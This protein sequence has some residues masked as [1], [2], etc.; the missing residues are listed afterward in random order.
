MNSTIANV[1]TPLRAAF[2]LMV[3]NSSSAIATGP[4]SLTRRLILRRDL[5]PRSP[6]RVAGGVARL[7]RG[8]VEHR[9]DFDE[10]AQSRWAAA[11]GP[12]RA[13][14]RRSSP[15]G[16]PARFRAC[17]RPCRDGR[18]RLVE[19]QLV[20]VDADQHVLE[21]GDQPAQAL[22]VAEIADQ[23]RRP[24]S[25]PARLCSS[26]SLGWNSRPC[27]AK[28]SAALELVTRLKV[29]LVLGERLRS[30]PS[31]PRRSVPASAPRRRRR[32]SRSGGTRSRTR[33]RAWRQSRSFDSSASMSELMTKWVAV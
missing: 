27:W 29:A 33:P 6:Q 24:A 28:N 23:R 20:L 25:E 31:S 30:A 26:S 2:S 12:R 4:V 19:R 14:A 15:A 16:P 8:E 22:V 7:Q 5:S 9:A 3:P 13:R 17:R 10:A 32:S 11:A 1:I 18:A 21:P